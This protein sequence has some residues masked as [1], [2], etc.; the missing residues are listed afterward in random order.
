MELNTAQLLTIEYT[1]V[2]MGLFLF[3]KCFQLKK[4]NMNFFMRFMVVLNLF[5]L[6][7]IPIRFV[8]LHL[9]M[10]NRDLVFL[11]YFFSVVLMTFSVAYWC[12]FVLKQVN[13]PLVNS[14]KKVRLLF[15]PAFISIP[16]CIINY[17]TGWLY[18]I[19]ENGWYTRGSIFVLQA[20]FSYGYVAVI[21][22]GCLRHLII[23]QDKTMAIKCS[24]CT[25]PSAI[26]TVLQIVFGGSYLLVGVIMTAWS[27]YIEICLN[28]QKAYELSEAIYSIND[29]LVHSY[30]QITNNMKTILALSG[31]YYALFE[32]D[33]ANDSFKEIKAPDYIS[34][35]VQRFTSTRECLSYAANEM[36]DDGYVGLMK[37]FFDSETIAENLQ[38]NDSF[39]VDAFSRNRKDWI[40]TTISI[41]GSKLQRIRCNTLQ[42]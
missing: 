3:Y 41:T 36:F 24:L 8:E 31:I 17:W 11:L 5:L 26:G 25:I 37:V 28:R 39:F 9:V 7:N 33:F 1:I 40:R 21:V 32:V 30:D 22:I 6:E 10:W 42:W 14:T 16:L 20:I 27:M 4:D 2:I 34:E 15:I 38:T 35:Y 19:D 13:S 12:L 23:D 29:E 18:M